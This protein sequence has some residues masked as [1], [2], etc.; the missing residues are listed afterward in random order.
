MEKIDRRRHYLIGLDTETCNAQVDENGKLDLSNS[1]VYD[2]GYQITDRH[3][4]VYIQRSFVIYETF[5]GCAELMESAYYAEKIPNY[6]D[7]IADGSRQLVRFFTMLKQFYEDV[8]TYNVDTCFAHNA[9]FDVRALNN[10]LRF[11]TGDDNRFFFTK[12]MQIWD[13]LKMARDTFGKE[14][15]YRKWCEVNGYMTNHNVPQPRM[16]A[17]VLYRYIT[18]NNDFIESHTGLEDVEIETIILKK[19]FD[20]HKKMRKNLYENA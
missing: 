10:T 12:D 3:G 19:C 13:T 4:N 8:H 5:V 2:I 7:E 16:T 17:E 20:K 9:G 6:W 15:T 11:V 14:P 1:L 18:N